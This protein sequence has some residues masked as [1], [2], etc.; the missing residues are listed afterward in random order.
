M[1]VQ[2]YAVLFALALLSVGALAQVYSL[3][4]F[5]KYWPIRMVMSE[6]KNR[7]RNIEGEATAGIE[8]PDNRTHS[9]AH[10]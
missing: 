3:W 7:F 2:T 10:E 4:R 1:K 5:I 8:P 6:V 9:L